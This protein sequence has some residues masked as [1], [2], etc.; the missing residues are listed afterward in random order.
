LPKKL[1]SFLEKCDFGNI[2]QI[3]HH[4]ATLFAQVKASVETCT[5]KLSDAAAKSEIEANC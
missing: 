5:N 4:L 1:E 2:C 3:W